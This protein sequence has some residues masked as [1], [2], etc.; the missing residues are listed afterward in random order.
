MNITRISTTIIITAIIIMT[1]LWWVNEVR[2]TGELVLAVA[3]SEDSQTPVDDMRITIESIELYSPETGWDTVIRPDTTISLQ[4]LNQREKL[5]ALGTANLSP[6]S[7]DSVRLV[8]SQATVVEE[9]SE[10][11]VILSGQNIRIPSQ[12][13]IGN[14]TTSSLVFTFKTEQALYKSRED[15]YILLPHIHLESRYDVM[16]N[17][18]GSS[19]SISAGDLTA[20]T[21]IT[22]DETGNSHYGTLLDQIQS[23]N[24]GVD[25]GIEIIYTDPTGTTSSD[26]LEISSQ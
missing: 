9:D 8:L 7:Y 13:R 22:L 23:V 26:S 18:T 24:Y 17:F 11:D 1:V 14:K 5:T 16:T 20:R 4:E 12:T 25:E 15:A 10:T 2:S 3:T 6:N 19:V 21:N